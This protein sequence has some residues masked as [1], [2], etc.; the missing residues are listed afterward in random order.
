M[1]E[2][3]ERTA[4][5]NPYEIPDVEAMRAAWKK[6]ETPTQA[7]QWLEMVVY[8]KPKRGKT[9]FLGSIPNILI[10][11]FDQGSSIITKQKFPNFR[12][13]RVA[14]ESFNDV[15]LWYWILKTQKHPFQA[16]AWDT[17]T[18][19]MELALQHVLAEKVQR[20]PRKSAY[21][22]E[23][24]DYG[25]AA[26]IMRHWITMYRTLPMH[27]IWVC[28]ERADEAPDEETGTQEVE[29]Y[30]PDLQPSV[31]SYLLGLVSLIGYAYRVHKDG[32]L[33]FRMAFDR[34]GTMAADRYGVMPKAIAN[35][36]WDKIMEHYG[37]ILTGGEDNDGD[38]NG[39]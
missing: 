30:V 3:N 18:M 16:V 37:K 29:W 27:K 24:D 34:P 14:V 9:H 12:G 13:K 8:G 5:A 1:A 39:S 25:R 10:L 19:A 35:P 15:A 20:D 38:G 11:D 21:K 32:K 2:A 7:A 31:R 28:H 23:Q 6:A 22:A 36:T 33:Q 17:A 26:R 4:L